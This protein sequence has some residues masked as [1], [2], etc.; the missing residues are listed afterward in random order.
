MT[1]E[2]RW[3]GTSIKQLEK[4]DK[5]IA[6]RIIQKVVKASNDPFKFVEKLSGFSLY[7]LRAGDYRIVMSI[8]VNRMT[9]FVLEVGHR[10][11][12]YRKY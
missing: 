1:Y 11:T 6:E 7:R 8:E 4:L 5:R 10:S 12:V 2:I 3:T 9:I